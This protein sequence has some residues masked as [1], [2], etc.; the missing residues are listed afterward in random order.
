MIGIHYGLNNYRRYLKYKYKYMD[1]DN[2]VTYKAML[3]NFKWD[4][5]YISL[6]SISFL[7]HWI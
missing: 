6:V 4:Y 2:V 3:S 1:V 7:N 5:K